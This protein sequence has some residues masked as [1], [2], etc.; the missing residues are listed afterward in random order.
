MPGT[1]CIAGLPRPHPRLP[2]TQSGRGISNIASGTD[3]EVVPSAPRARDGAR[4]GSLVD[5]VLDEV[6]V[7]VDGHELRRELTSSS[8]RRRPRA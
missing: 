1:A 5:A 4:E 7:D 2:G 8:L 3:F 6:F